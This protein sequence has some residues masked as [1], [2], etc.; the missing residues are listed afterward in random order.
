MARY[1]T[2]A[3]FLCTLTSPAVADGISVTPQN[4]R[5]EDD[6]VKLVYK[7]T[8]ETGRYIETVR[9]KCLIFDRGGEIL[10]VD[11]ETGDKLQPKQTDYVKSIASIESPT[12]GPLGKVE[13]RV[14]EVE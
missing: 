4:I 5:I 12:H 3:A 14:L 11:Q 7:V 13:C 9:F 1:L 2:L 8:N 10:A 6:F